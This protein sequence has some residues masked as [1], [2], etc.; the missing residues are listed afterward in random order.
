MVEAKGAAQ[1][2]PPGAK[3]APDKAK[4]QAA[5][6]SVKALAGKRKTQQKRDNRPLFY[7]AAL[8]FAAVLT[9]VALSAFKKKPA[10]NLVNSAGTAGAVN[11]RV[12]NAAGDLT[13]APRKK[14]SAGATSAAPARSTARDRGLR[15][16]EPVASRPQGGR[17][18]KTP[19]DRTSRSRDQSSRQGSS[20]GILT[21]IGVGTA[22]VGSRPV[23]AGDVIRDRVIQEI[24]ADAIKVEYNGTVYTVRIGDALP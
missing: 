3:A 24:G 1:K 10:A 15:Q 23:Q 6:K 21:A 5:S 17:A 16:R 12:T 4:A 20:S 2:N 14:P 7:G 8:V 22:M 18:P 13:A 11:R 9:I 19:A